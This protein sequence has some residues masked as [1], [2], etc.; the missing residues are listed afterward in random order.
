MKKL[1]FLPVLF[2]LFSFTA[3][4]DLK[5]ETNEKSE[6]VKITESKNVN[7]ETVITK[8]VTDKVSCIHY[9]SV[10]VGGEHRYT[11]KSIKESDCGFT[12]R[13]FE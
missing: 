12:I 13:W 2:L 7:G 3:K 8:V 11:F 5:V 10:F 6:I 1:F 4:S 9:T